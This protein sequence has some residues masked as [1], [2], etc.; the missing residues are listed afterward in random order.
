MRIGTS[1]CRNTAIGRIVSYSALSLLACLCTGIQA[2]ELGSLKSELIQQVGIQGQWKLGQSCV[3]SVRIPS[4]LAD[5]AAWIHVTTLDGDG[6]EVVYRQKLIAGA[7]QTVNVPIR[8]GR[9]GSMLTATLLDAQH[10]SLALHN[11]S[12]A[13]YEGLAATQPMILCV[14]STMGLDD[15]VRA[16]QDDTQRSLTLIEVT[17]A[18]ELPKSWLEYQA[19][20]LV[21]LSTSNVDLLRNIQ[22]SQWQ[23]LNDWIRRGGS[24]IISL[25]SKASDLQSFQ[26][27]L[28]L[29]PGQ[30]KADCWIDNPAALEMVITEQRLQPFPAIQIDAVNGEVQ[31]SLR[32]R[33]AKQVPWWTKHAHG[34]GIVQTIAS[35]LDHPSFAT[36]KQRKVLWEKLIALN[37]DKK[38]IE[39]TQGDQGSTTSY[40]GYGDLIGQLRATLDQFTGLQAIGFSQIAAI[41]VAIL[42]LIGPVDYFVCVRWLNRPGLSWLLAAVVL[43][44]SATALAGYYQAIRPDQ[45]ICNRAQILDVDASS[46]R[47]DGHLWMHVY[48]GRARQLGIASRFGSNNDGVFLD[49]QGLPGSGLGGLQSTLVMQNGMP[50]YEIEVHDH[51][52]ADIANV[53]IPSS[54]TKSLFGSFAAQLEFTGE[55]ELREV[56]S[57]VDQLVGQVTNPM[58]FELRD[59]SLFYHKWYYSL[60]S[61]MAAGD[62]IEI[63][64]QLIPK[65]L[66]RRLN[67]QQEID[68]KATSTRWNPAERGDLDR[69]MELMM[70]HK[71][72]TGRN[73]TSLTHYYQPI[74]D[75]SNIL[76]TDCAILV[77]RIEDSP[78]T[79]QFRAS[80]LGD[81]TETRIGLDRTWCRILIPVKRVRSTGPNRIG[82]GSRAD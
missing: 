55:S 3:V 59:V 33:L 30:L 21:V 75:H 41:L 77:G 54:G 67:R 5:Q 81:S 46:G 34:F 19:C 12:L 35:D 20:N 63:S 82:L 17:Q 37:V 43:S 61:R 16:N 7:P 56:D 48:S 38:Q 13:E 25:G 68:G 69:L 47:V 53:G 78:V 28:A 2:E 23:A 57:S 51:R 40:L 29:L 14:G 49:W 11:L 52:S 64:S 26:E 24:C 36:W 18:D 60:R 73:Y 27:L 71:A 10:Q 44:I 31:L 72:A 79:Y 45:I 62:S 66:G 74:V 80:D 4:E 9:T 65:D 58:A 50:P 15:L 39:S 32:D 6:V 42:I 1:C 76:E 70:F 22:P 8:I